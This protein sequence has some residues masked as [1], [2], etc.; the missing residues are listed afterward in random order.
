M[1][2]IHGNPL[3]V[4]HAQIWKW[5]GINTPGGACPMGDWSW[6][7]DGLFFYSSGGHCSCIWHSSSRIFAG[8]SPS[9]PWQWSAWKQ[10]LALLSYLNLSNSPLLFPGITSQVNYL[11]SSACLQFCFQRDSEC[12]VAMSLRE[13]NIFCL[14]GS[15]FKE[16]YLYGTR[17]R[18]LKWILKV[19]YTQPLNLSRPP[20]NKLKWSCNPGVGKL[21]L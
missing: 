16:L 3:A 9:H 5:E 13:V 8:L 2:D 19:T 18:L 15:I 17:R 7:I 12:Y 20:S 14:L 1:R 4:V 6:W 21:F 11:H 10:S